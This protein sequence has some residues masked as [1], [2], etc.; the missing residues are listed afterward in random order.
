VFP[1]C[2]SKHYGPGDYGQR[3][4]ECDNTP[5]EMACVMWTFILL[6]RL[7]I[8]DNAVDAYHG[9]GEYR[10]MP[11]GQAGR[12]KVCR[13]DLGIDG[14][15]F[16]SQVDFVAILK[17]ATK[18]HSQLMH[19]FIVSDPNDTADRSVVGEY[20]L[21]QQFETTVRFL[22]AESGKKPL[23][24]QMYLGEHVTS[25]Q[26][27]SRTRGLSLTR[28]LK[29][30]GYLNSKHMMIGGTGAR[31]GYAM[32]S[33]RSVGGLDVEL[34]NDTHLMNT[35]AVRHSSYYDHSAARRSLP[36]NLG[37][38]TM[39]EEVESH[40]A[41][42][43]AQN[44][45]PPGYTRP[46]FF[47]HENHTPQNGSF[48]GLTDLFEKLVGQKPSGLPLR[49]PF[50]GCR[51][52]LVEVGDYVRHLHEEC[53]HR[54]TKNAICPCCSKTIE[55][56]PS[57]HISTASDFLKHLRHTC[58]EI[59]GPFLS[60]SNAASKR[61]G[62][63]SAASKAILPRSITCE[64]CSRRFHSLAQHA[65]HLRESRT[66]E[67]SKCLRE[68]ASNNDEKWMKTFQW[69]KTL[70]ETPGKLQT[71]VNENLPKGS[72]YQPLK[73]WLAKQARSDRTL[74]PQKVALLR[75]IGYYNLSFK[76][77]RRVKKEEY[78]QQLEWYRQNCGGS[79]PP[80]AYSHP[81]GGSLGKWLANT[82]RK[83]KKGQLTK[84]QS[85]WLVQ[86]GILS[87]GG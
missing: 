4:A 43:I 78:K 79:D 3:V 7:G 12:L 25:Y 32:F 55:C 15:Q 75:S 48:G 39:N 74:S 26:Q 59:R 54:N 44:P 68:G 27:D 69:A 22:L 60:L 57:R 85:E 66:C 10:L 8:I 28:M 71:I 18:K 83:H 47:D 72:M 37:M 5:V 87:R 51:I 62:I 56:N 13:V 58:P 24:R 35:V 6:Q 49:C 2:W 73:R 23:Y 1:F 80:D 67:K 76:K 21:P 65:K 86:N 20:T 17:S 70:A 46:R 11:H 34:H 33:R 77:T 45:L 30:A 64:G 38:G 81:D 36:A 29:R 14:N 31:K 9:R 52:E 84:E 53:P 40:L 82:R 63:N 19:D 50:D 42:R 41:E 16:L 61:T